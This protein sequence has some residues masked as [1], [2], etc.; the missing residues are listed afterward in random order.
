MREHC[1]RYEIDQT[2]IS[3]ILFSSLEVVIIRPMLL[4]VVASSDGR[5]PSLATLHEMK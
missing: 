1:W 2:A 3:V 4:S 5:M